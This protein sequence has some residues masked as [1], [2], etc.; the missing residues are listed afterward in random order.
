MTFS[1]KPVQVG[2]AYNSY[3]DQMNE[4]Q[5]KEFDYIEIPFELLH[6]DEAVLQRINHK[7]LILHCASLS[8]AGYAEPE[9]VIK[10]RIQHFIQ[11][12]GTPWV[13]E[14][15]SF[16]L[17]EKL[18][19]NFYDE[20]A[21]GEPY[22]IGYTVSPV[23]NAAS[24][25]HIIQ[26]ICRY[27]EAF[28]TN[29]I[30]ENP[31][32]Y[33]SVPGSTMSQLDFINT[34]CNNSP[35]ELLLDLTHFFISSQNFSYDP[36]AALQKFP[37]HRVKEVHVSGVNTDSGI[38]WDNHATEAPEIIFKLLEIV[39]KNCTPAAVTLEYNWAS[40]IPWEKLDSELNK[41]KEVMYQCV[42]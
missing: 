3:I 34:I 21:P 22:N 35:T 9:T 7:P 30:V 6:F 26:K 31:P 20:Y 29:I 10:N 39:L 13:G 23:M 18:D 24:A 15:L 38:M 11:A 12:T 42:N 19:D 1:T 32:L 5:L 8:L 14:H 41:V 33:F 25:E 4:A 27:K 16:I 2:L 40:T 28:G 37:L 17:A 36:L